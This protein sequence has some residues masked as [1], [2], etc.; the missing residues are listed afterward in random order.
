MS[1]TVTVQVSHK[2][3]KAEAVRR[4]EEGLART[5]GQLGSLISIDQT[6]WQDDSVRLQ[7]RALGQSAAARIQVLEKALLIEVELPGLLG[8][9]AKRLVPILR[10]EATALLEKK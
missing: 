2:L 8:K 4:L 7:M 3:G 5:S 9:L 1:D 6:V 10:R